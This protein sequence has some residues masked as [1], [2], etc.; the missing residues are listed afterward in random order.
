[1]EYACAFLES[2]G[3]HNSIDANFGVVVVYAVEDEVEVYVFV[4]P[5]AAHYSKTNDTLAGCSVECHR[6]IVMAW[7][8]CHVVVLR[9]YHVEFSHG[10][11]VVKIVYFFRAVLL[12]KQRHLLR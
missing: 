2:I 1:M 12:I 6:V 4:G 7:E 11:L 5:R 10:S 3:E 9:F 8:I